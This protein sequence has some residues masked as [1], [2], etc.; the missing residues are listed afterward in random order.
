MQ[1][2][3]TALILYALRVLHN[4]NGAIDAVKRAASASPR[5]GAATTRAP[6]AIIDLNRDVDLS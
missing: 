1:F 2:L 4:L 6:A 3:H 5:I